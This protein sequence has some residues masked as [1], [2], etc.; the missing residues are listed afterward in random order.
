M[1]FTLTQSLIER[2]WAKVDRRGEHWM[3]TGAVNPSGYGTIGSG[4][5]YGK[6]LYA[7][8]VAFAIQNGP[9]PDGLMVRHRCDI[10]LCM[11]GEDL[12]PGT[13]ADNMKDRDERGRTSKG[14]RHSRVMKKKAARGDRNGSR[15]KPGCLPR[16]D[17]HWLRK[18]PGA[19]SGSKNPLTNLTEE[20]VREIRLL[21]AGNLKK[22]RDIA[23]DYGISPPA[24]TAI[25]QRRTWKHVE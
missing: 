2:F 1:T 15:T 18:N 25:I 9:L 6:T 19:R 17:N 10:K 23:R 11:R 4:G 16:G 22:K 13:H 7:H 21:V 8:H 3:W 5:K 14:G 24:L 12:I 20:K